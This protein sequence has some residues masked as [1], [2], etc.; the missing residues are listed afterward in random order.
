MRFKRVISILVVCIITLSLA[1][2]LFGL[3]S[4]NGQG[5]YEFKSIHGE[6]VKI[7]GKGIYK[8][9]SVTVASQA[10]AQDVVT[11]FLGIPLLIFSLILARRGL[12][13][14]RLLLA[15][16]L[17]YFLYTYASYS[18]LSMYNPLF[19][20]YVL[21]LSGSFFAFSLTMM[22]FDIANLSNYFNPKLPVRFIGGFLII[23]SVMIGLMW[24]GRIVPPLLNNSFPQ[25]LE[26][27]TT[28]V[29]QA[30][31]IGFILPT[32]IISG[33]LILKRRAFGYLLSSVII[34]KGITLLTAITA[35]II[36]QALAGVKMNQLE[37]MIFPIFN[38]VV[39]Y[40]L[41]LIMKNIKE[42]GF[43]V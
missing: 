19:I 33:V 27:Y 2:A 22:S 6:L 35:M 23:L 36:G 15:G 4:N 28:L 25:G 41:V 32:G 20:V 14:G 42:P 16:T 30:L 34:I 1:A 43:P 11:L 26:H 7:Y 17:G 29:I 37:V 12:I 40:C 10:I 31:D 24:L 39:I 38:L 8:Y 5:Q 21:L 3:L 18:F 9:D 13:K